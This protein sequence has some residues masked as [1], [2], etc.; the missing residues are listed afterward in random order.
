MK[1]FSIKRKKTHQ[2]ISYPQTPHQMV[3]MKVNIRFLINELPVRELLFK[4][5]MEADNTCD[6]CDTQTIQTIEHVLAHY[7]AIVN[8][9]QII[10]LWS[11]ILDIIKVIF[12]TNNLVLA[13]HFGNKSQKSQFI[14]NPFSLL[15]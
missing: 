14:I 4:K 10:K 1:D 3:K 5:D 15:F 7:H 6:I 9:P 12:S 2:I 13:N 8:D 11:H